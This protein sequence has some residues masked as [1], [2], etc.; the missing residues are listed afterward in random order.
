MV[1][2]YG[3]QFNIDSTSNVMR[4]DVLGFEKVTFSDEHFFQEIPKKKDHFNINR[5]EKW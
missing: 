1:F 2:M 5:E 4:K 3:N